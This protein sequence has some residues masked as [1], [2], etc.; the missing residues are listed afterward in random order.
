VAKAEVSV[1]MMLSPEAPHDTYG[2]DD[3][4]CS[5]N[6][7]LPMN[8]GM[9]C[10]LSSISQIGDQIT[11]QIPPPA[12]LPCP[13]GPSL[14]P[15]PSHTY[16]ATARA[17]RVEAQHAVSYVYFPPP[18]LLPSP[19]ALGQSPRHRHEPLSFS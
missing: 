15:A 5:I 11:A 1:T 3:G 19:A 14:E 8:D 18:L 17:P 16:S 2:D 13:R 7:S 9:F 10:R 4:S 6:E 12:H